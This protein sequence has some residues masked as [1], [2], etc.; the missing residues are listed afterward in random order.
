MVSLPAIVKEINVGTYKVQ[1]FQLDNGEYRYGYDFLAD[2]GEFDKRDLSDKKNKFYVYKL[3]TQD[4]VN[5]L[6][7]PKV[8]LIGTRITYNSLSECQIMEALE[9]L[10]L[11]GCMKVLRF[12]TVCAVENL[13]RRADKVYD[14]DRTEEERERRFKARLA[15][16]VV[17]RS[18]TNAIKDYLDRNVSSVS[19]NHKKWIYSNVSDALNLA[20]F[21]KKAKDLCAERNV[22]RENLRDSHSE[23]ELKQIDRHEDYAVRI[24]DKLGTEPLQAINEAIAFYS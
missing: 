10:V 3:C 4:T 2:L 14:N 13:E 24:I 7:N 17:R 1:A 23:E 5:V 22:K 15:G 21:G 20:I 19:V 9:N 12:L 8:Q 11:L 16:K 18:L 6:T